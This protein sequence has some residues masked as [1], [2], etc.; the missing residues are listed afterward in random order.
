M[1]DEQI[2]AS[3]LSDSH[4]RCLLEV[5]IG[6]QYQ[7]RDIAKKMHVGQLT[8]LKLKESALKK[9]H[10]AIARKYIARGGTVKIKIRELWDMHD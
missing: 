9:M 1:T 10:T 6:T 5:E 7:Y 2:I 8:V 4:L 3:I